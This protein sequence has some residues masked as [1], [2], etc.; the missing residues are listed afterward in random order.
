VRPVVALLGFVACTVSPVA[1][2]TRV[3]MPV[4]A[5]PAPDVVIPGAE[6]PVESL[7]LAL[8]PRLDFFGKPLAA[9]P[10]ELWRELGEQ[11][12]RP[13]AGAQRAELL[14]R[15]RLAADTWPDDLR[16]AE[17]TGPWWELRGDPVAWSLVRAVDLGAPEDARDLLAGG[18][19]A[20]VTV[21]RLAAIE[22]PGTCERTPALIDLLARSE[23][24][25]RVHTL[26]LVLP[27]CAGAEVVA[28]LGALR[29]PGVRRL[30]APRWPRPRTAAALAGLPWLAQ[31]DELDLAGAQPGAAGLAALG[32]SP[33][34]QRLAVLRL[35]GA[36]RPGD[37]VGLAD[38]PGLAGLRVLDLA[39]AEL[40]AAGLQALGG[41]PALAGLQELDLRR[42]VLGPDELGALVAGNGLAGLRVLRLDGNPLGDE[43]LAVLRVARQWSGLRELSAARAELGPRA[44]VAVARARHLQQL[45]RLD[46]AGNPLGAAGGL[47]LAGA[48]HLQ[49]LRHLDL[50]GC[51]IDGH[52]LAGLLQGLTRPE[53]LRLGG[54]HVGDAGARAIAAHTDWTG[55]RVL[56]LRGAAI[57]PDGFVALAGAPQL[58]T[59]ERL[60]IAGNDPGERGWRA[61]LASQA[62][63][64]F[65][66]PEWRAALALHDTRLRPED[67]ARAIPAD[68]ELVLER[69]GCPGRCLAHALTLRADGSLERRDLERVDRRGPTLGRVDDARLR[70]VLAAV[71]RLLASQP[72]RSR[73]GDPGCAPPQDDLAE[74]RVRVR[75]DGA[76]VD[77]D[78][79][80]MCSG[81][82]A[83]R[84][85]HEFARRVEAV[86]APDADRPAP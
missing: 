29:L 56:D 66:T 7:R 55:L 12:Q 30:V 52:G 33:H 42:G 67:V 22:A 74:V 63:A 76:L 65:A 70:L 18:A 73:P 44:A 17:P 19:L 62:L 72:D 77:L 58:A 64:R 54:N 3:R 79:E 13:M 85:L 45:E 83:W 80:Q 32:R 60:D 21:L 23:P 82:A 28:G 69:G 20:E 68:F 81:A 39:D 71:D 11:L 8:P 84:G 5:A 59:L 51:G 37:L 75:Q 36:V 57:G 40:D 49:G 9:A 15:A 27:G 86:L 48:D 16:R 10:A 35:R 24:L 4:A 2:P 6:D 53:V 50:G 46:L 61:L 78:S 26:H 31:L 14:R 34:L 41:N 38:T 1:R 25:A 43:G 47:M